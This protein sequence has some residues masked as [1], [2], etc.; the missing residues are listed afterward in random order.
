MSGTKLTTFWGWLITAAVLALASAPAV[1]LAAMALTSSSGQPVWTESFAQ[2]VGTSLLL[3]LGVAVTS[4]AVGLPL[5]LLVPLYRFPGRSL[6]ATAQTLPLLLPSFLP[7]IGWSNLAAAGWFPRLL[8][9]DGFSGCVFVLGLQAVPL[10]F[11]ATWAAALNLTGSQVDAARLAGGETAVLRHSAGACAPVAVLAALLAGVLSLSDTGAPLIFGCRSAAVE[12]RTTFAALYDFD[13]AGRQCLALAGLVLLL[14]APLLIVGLRLLGAA[15]LARQT[16]P[17]T[18]YHHAMLGRIAPLALLAILVI[19]IGMPT[20]GL[21]LPAVNDPMPVRA[22]AKA[23]STVGATFTYTFGA[24]AVAVSAATC[25]ALLAGR[26]LRLRLAV[27]GVLLMLL[28]MPPAL[29]ALGT[30]YAA[31]SAPPEF[32]WLLRSQLTVAVVLG[33]RFLPV[34]A[35]IMMRAVGTLS[36]SWTDAAKVHGVSRVRFLLRVILPLLAPAVLVGVLL[37]TVLAA[38]DITTIHLLQPTTGRPSLPLAIFTVMANSPEGL[39]AS[40]CLIY[41]SGVVAL[42]AVAS[43]LSRVL[44]RRTS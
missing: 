24:G 8:C 19:G 41:L 14:T 22:A 1:P 20:L 6:L 39:V 44:R 16:R 26:D 10:V 9:P 36:P 40:L 5:G 11:F 31:T 33:L 35:V 37:V 28:A 3:G 34:A 4:L 43:Q 13:L 21:C 42:M 27:L 7:A 23:W 32:D 17:V 29:G 18:P 12:I 38:A 25:L 15:I 30:S 2:T